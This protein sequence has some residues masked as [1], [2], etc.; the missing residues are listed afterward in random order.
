MFFDVSATIDN[1]AYY[2]SHFP[3][4]GGTVF[5]ATRSL[6]RM[7]DNV[8]C[9]LGLSYAHRFGEV[10]WT[11]QLNI[12]NLFDKSDVW[13]LPNPANDAQLRARLSSQPRLFVWSN[14]F[15]F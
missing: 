11:T 7:P 8:I 2:T 9:G 13:V 10:T 12:R 6:V 14:T 1:R 5:D 4:S 3:S 15:S